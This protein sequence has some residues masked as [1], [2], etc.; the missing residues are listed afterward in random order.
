[1]WLTPQLFGMGLQREV[2]LKTHAKSGQIKAFRL[3]GEVKSSFH[4]TMIYA[5][6]PTK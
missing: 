2:A 4:F 5:R 1:M 3:C 6:G